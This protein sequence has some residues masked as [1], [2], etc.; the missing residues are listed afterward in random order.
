M[1]FLTNTST[2]PFRNMAFDEFAL[3]GLDVGEPVFYLWRN[4]PAV[5]IGLNQNAEA[6]VDLK[7]LEDNGIHLVRRVTGGGAVYHDLQNLNYSIVG[8]LIQMEDGPG[9]IEKAL[10]EMGLP[11]ERTGR[12]DLTVQGRKCSGYAKRLHKNRMMVHGTLMWDVDIEK[13]TR[14]LAAPGSKLSAKGVESVRSRVANLKEYLP[15]FSGIKDFAN[16]L[17]ALLAQN[18]SEIILAKEQQAAIDALADEKFRKWEW[19]FGHGPGSSFQNSRK[20]PCGT[21]EV[22][23]SLRHGVFE[24]LCFGGDFMGAAPAEEL[25][26][27]LIG[28]KPEMLL[29]VDTSKFFDGLRPEELLTLFR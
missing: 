15:Q 9:V 11:V 24:S 2:D 21:I 19:N 7:Y 20:F 28:Q 16:A 26:A 13:L 10:K 25:A 14:A 4:S 5:I 27:R 22:Q 17:Q 8:P 1:K 29:Q 6:E 18:D 3:E 12:N 23:Y